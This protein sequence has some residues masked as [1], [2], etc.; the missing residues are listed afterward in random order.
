MSVKHNLLAPFLFPFLEGKGFVA[1]VINY[2]AG[3]IFST[4]K[5]MPR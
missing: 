4:I 1:D 2:V 3:L 5:P